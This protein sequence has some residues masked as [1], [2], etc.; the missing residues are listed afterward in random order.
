MQHVTETHFH[1]RLEYL[2]KIPSQLRT[3]C[4]F[5]HTYTYLNFMEHVKTQVDH[6]PAWKMNSRAK[7]AVKFSKKML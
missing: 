7:L 3:F 5:V 6:G 4:I 1:S 2:F